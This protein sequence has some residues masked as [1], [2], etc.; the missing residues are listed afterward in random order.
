MEIK[1]LKKADTIFDSYVEL[2]LCAESSVFHWI[3]LRD[4]CTCTE[5]FHD[6][7]VQ[8]TLDTFD[9][10]PWKVCRQSYSAEAPK[11]AEFEIRE[12]K[13]ASGEMAG[14]AR[15]RILGGLAASP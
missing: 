15:K 13:L 4:N 9:E 12:G 10:L 8:R 7:T 5:C 1:S 2:A 6:A 14:R 11:E 3:Y